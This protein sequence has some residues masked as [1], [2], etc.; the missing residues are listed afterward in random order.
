MPSVE[1]R[2]PPQPILPL[3]DPPCDAQEPRIAILLAHRLF[4]D[5]GHAQRFGV[6]RRFPPRGALFPDFA[7]LAAACEGVH[8][9]FPERLPAPRAP[10]PQALGERM[11]GVRDQPAF[12][13]RSDLR[14][15][16]LRHGVGRGH[17]LLRLSAQQMLFIDRAIALARRPLRDRAFWRFFAL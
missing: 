12:D 6:G 9:F 17:L 5:G 3:D 15:P 10:Q 16:L 4:D 1:P 2:R 8:R 13:A 14:H 7:I 11:F